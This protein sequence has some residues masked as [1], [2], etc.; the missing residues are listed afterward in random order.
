[1]ESRTWLGPLSEWRVRSKPLP[2]EMASQIRAQQQQL[3]R[4]LE[5]GLRELNAGGQSGFDG[6]ADVLELLAALPTP[7]EILNL[8]PSARLAARVEELIG[9]SRSGQMTSAD[10]Q[11]W[12]RYEYLEHLVRMEK[13]AAQLKLALSRAIIIN[14]VTGEIL[15]LSTKGRA[16]IRLLRMNRPARIKERQSGRN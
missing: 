6:A 2:E 7:E 14:F 10:E 8:R 1:M 5:L 13:A 9:K 15:G 4:I 3:P 12:E 16:T 11:D